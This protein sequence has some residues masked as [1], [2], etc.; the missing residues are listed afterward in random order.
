MRSSIQSL[1]RSLT[2]SLTSILPFL[3]GIAIYS[4]LGVQAAIR[5]EESSSAAPAETFGNNVQLRGRLDR[6]RFRF[7]HDHKGAVAFM[8]GSI[9]E[10]DGYRVMVG[11][12]LKRRFPQTEFR[13][14]NAGIASTCST[15][16]AFRLQSDLFAAGPVDL[17]FVEFAVND[18]QDAH[19]TREECIRGVEGI[20]RHARSLNPNVDIVVTY[21]VNPE[22]LELHRK[23]REPLPIEAHEAVAERYGISTIHVGREVAEEIAAG[24]LTWE[25]YGGT[26]PAP[27]GHA[28]CARM[29]DTLLD[30]AWADAP[31]GRRPGPYAQPKPIDP[32]SYA[33]GRMVSPARA[34]S[35]HDWTFAV[36]DW[37]KLPGEKRARFRSIPMLCADT[38]GAEADFEF[39]GTTVGAYI[40]AGPD[41]GIVLA[42][43]DGGPERAIDLYHP[44]SGGLHYPRTVIFGTDLKPGRHRLRLKIAGETHSKGHAA[45]IMQFTVNGAG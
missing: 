31:A 15:T 44:F 5:P 11:D 1:A 22:M 6:A 20:I 2:G 25:T 32:G 37:Q 10:I 35:L 33:Q 34:R 28:L 3:L 14:I 40:V 43:I 29:I 45:R 12:S 17:L 24:R 19:H 38:V 18:D 23:G 42:S 7:Q 30:R 26:H 8:G 36:P 27:A 4:S 41:A 39:S 16:G 13:M 21:F 9:T